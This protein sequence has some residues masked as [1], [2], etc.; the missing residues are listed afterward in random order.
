MLEISH[1]FKTYKTGNFVQKALDDVSLNFRDNEFVAILGPSGSG[2]TTLLN[3]IGGLDNY[4]RGD[5]IINGVSTKLYKDKKWDSYRNHTIGF[6]FQSYNL[7]PHQ[8]ILSN[9]E[10][11]L[12]IAGI[13]GK[14]KKALALKALDNVG[15]KMQASKKPNELS[16][17]QMQRVAIAR[18]LVNN[19]SIVL[20]DEPTGALDSDTSIQ[21][22]DLLKEVAKDRLVIMVTHNPDLAYK[23]AN[24]IINLKDGKIT[25]DS[26]PFKPVSFIKKD[27]KKIPKANMSF[28]TALSLSF[29]NLLSKKGRTILTSIAGSIGI[30]GISLILALSTG[31]QNYINKIQDDTMSSYP[32]TIQEETSNLFTAL[33]NDQIS[34]ND[35]DTSDGLIHEQT[36]IASMFNSA[37]K[38]DLK[39][40]IA[41]LDN[42]KDLYKDDVKKIEYSYSIT[43]LIY[44]KDITDSIVQVNPSTITSLIYSDEASSLLS[45]LGSSASM[46]VFIKSDEDTLKSSTTLLKGYYPEKYNEV[47][48]VL[49]EKDQIPDLLVYSLGLRDN[50]VLTQLIND[51]MANKENKIISNPLTF[52]YDDLLN[53]ELKLIDASSLYRYN[54]SYHTYEDMSDDK[55]YL[56]TLYDKSEDLIITGIAYS[57][58]SS[59]TGI[60]YN[61]SLIDHIID[62]ASN[63]QIV[64]EQM[65]NPSIDIFSG[66]A[67]NDTEN[68][69]DL[70]LND[71]ISVDEDK[72]K[73]AFKFNLDTSSL[74]NTDYASII[75]NN[76]AMIKQ[77]IVSTT[78]AFVELIN[79]TDKTIGETLIKAYNE[80]SKQDITIAL[81]C[82]L[83]NYVD[84]SNLSLGCIFDEN[85]TEGVDY[86][87]INGFKFDINAYNTTTY[88]YYGEYLPN[89]PNL[90]TVDYFIN[91]FDTN[92]EFNQS[93]DNICQNLKDNMHLSLTKD[94]IKEVAYDIF[95]AYFSDVLNSSYLDKDTNLIK[96]TDLDKISIDSIANNILEEKATSIYGEAYESAKELIN[97][98]AVS[99][100]SNAIK[101]STSPFVKLFENMDKAISF[102]SEA[103]SSAFKFNLDDEELSRLMSSMLTKSN[104]SY[105]NNLIKLG[106]Q[107]KD[108]PTSISFYFNSF[109]AKDNFIDFIDNYNNLYKDEEKDISYSDMTGI[110]M[111]SVSTII[112]AITYVLIAFVSISLI[113]SSIMIAVI[114]LISVMERY[115]EIGILRA[116]GA[117]KHNISSIFNAETFII[118]LLSGLFGIMISMFLTIPINNIIHMLTG[119]EDIKAILY[120]KY[121]FILVLI[122]VILT[123][124][125][126]YIPSKKA[127][128][129]DPAK[130]LRSE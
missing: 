10:L 66:N 75:L 20:A 41:Y 35:K 113:V 22:M 7:I 3:I 95:R 124:L 16:G 60:V 84:S 83:D 112:N 42:N 67:F 62:K 118:G 111:S 94:E 123:V 19:P 82:P 1:I 24:R 130:A 65:A 93:L 70:N 106:Y 126:G 9:V 107:A 102:D 45:T 89:D 119:I 68:D 14:K 120:P 57:N 12:T 110:L 90:K 58:D 4:D 85:A 2:K 50:K 88:I 105:K 101:E 32:L 72:I 46:G 49:K 6:I 40:F 5:L 56:K 43:P 98:L 52:T 25:H 92:E 100:I 64:K 29:N 17:G 47:M 114:T 13:K 125:S 61:D 79:N 38:N 96:L 51:L 109:K 91:N 55:A 36:I 28:I 44:T 54:D 77:S 117:S 8:S 86:I 21:V 87:T 104:A 127:A 73:N 31:F 108:E 37:G 23:Y 53:R 80:T 115:K 128:R 63:S 81:S 99:G 34:K 26:N 97:L 30:I 71:L 18:A 129:Q 76:S 39:S 33:L 11:S 27:N 48:I 59:L 69:R 103:F 15:L 74:S 122:S 121:A 116:M 78:D